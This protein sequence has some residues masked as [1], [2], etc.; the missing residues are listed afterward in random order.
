MDQRPHNTLAVH[1][2]RNMRIRFIKSAETHVLRQHVL[3]PTQAIAEMEWSHDD[4]EGSFHL[5]A[6]EDRDGS[7]DR[8]ISVASFVRE[9]CLQ[10]PGSHQYRLRGM[11]TAQ[12]H[13]GKGIGA[14]L[15]RFGLEHL[16]HLKADLVWCNA[17]E[18]ALGFY[19]REGFTSQGA[20]FMIEGIGLHHL[21]FRQL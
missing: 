6:E 13:R 11:A 10:L 21:L 1:P 16:H 2:L 14:A 5:G 3:R 20:A 8:L 15:L 17:R 7:D 4:A 9:R 18:G 19:E 12:E